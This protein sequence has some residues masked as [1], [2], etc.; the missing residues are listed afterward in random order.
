MGDCKNSEGRL[1]EVT[2]RNHIRVTVCSF[3]RFRQT[4]MAPY[5]DE[6]TNYSQEQKMDV[7]VEQVLGGRLVYD[8]VLDD[9]EKTRGGRLQDRRDFAVTGGRLNA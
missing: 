6:R 9:S 8:T 1:A 7:A 5:R 4:I 3:S 2:W